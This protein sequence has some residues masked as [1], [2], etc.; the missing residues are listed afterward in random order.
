MGSFSPKQVPWKPPCQHPTLAFSKGPRRV[1]VL[2]WINK[3]IKNLTATNRQ[4]N[5]PHIPA[6]DSLDCSPHSQI[7]ID[8]KE[9][10]V[11]P[12]W[13]PSERR[14]LIGK[15]LWSAYIYLKSCVRFSTSHLNHMY[16][17]LSELID[18]IY[19][20]YSK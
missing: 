4:I 15:F 13:V 3:A 1:R 6:V 16:L 17:I 12:M 9:N 5:G 2:R 10:P 18:D 19:V 8:P 14:I 11:G 7:A 20:L